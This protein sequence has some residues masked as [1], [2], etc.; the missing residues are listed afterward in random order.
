MKDAG[1]AMCLAHILRKEVITT[2]IS[3]IDF[4]TLLKNAPSKLI[5]GMVA[6][7]TKRHQ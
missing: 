4:E 1:V 7:Q 2:A 3:V 5:G 6:E